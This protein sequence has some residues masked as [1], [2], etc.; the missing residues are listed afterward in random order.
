VLE[1]VEPA[2]WMLYLRPREED[3][4]ILFFNETVTLASHKEVF[5][6]TYARGQGDGRKE[7]PLRSPEVLMYLKKSMLGELLY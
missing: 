5:E 6:D 7:M 2:R 1:D 4:W 3:R